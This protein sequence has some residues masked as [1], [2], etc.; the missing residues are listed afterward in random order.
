[1]SFKMTGTIYSVGQTQQVSDK[2]SK[3]EIVL[4][5]A[6]SKY[7]Q[8]ICFQFSQDKCNDL[9]DIAP[10]QEVEVSFNLKGR[11]W[12]DP[13]GVVKTFNTLEGWKIEVVG[14]APATAQV[15]SE[16]NDSED[17]LPF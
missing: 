14:N 15:I 8:F 12:T 7:P 16:N 1:M 17:A 9:N 11:N 13:Q 6:S 10:G 3:R 5:D 4:E 2:F